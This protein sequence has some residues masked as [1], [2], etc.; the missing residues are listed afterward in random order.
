[1]PRRSRYLNG[2]NLIIYV[3][4]VLLAIL[5]QYGLVMSFVYAGLRDI[6]LL[7]IPVGG[8]FQIG[9]L[10]HLIPL[11]VILVL[12]YDWIY[13]VEHKA[14]GSI[15]AAHYKA[16]AAPKADRGVKSP[17]SLIY[18]LWTG[19]KVPAS[20]TALFAFL[21]LTSF[22][23]LCPSILNDFAASL[24]HGSI[25]F[26]GLI[27]WSAHINSSLIET[28]VFFIASFRISLEAPF[29]SIIKSILG[30]D[31]IWKYLICQNIAAWA[32]T[33]Y[34]LT[35]VRHYGTKRKR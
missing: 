21:L 6:A 9:V 26:R 2:R 8:G 13:L 28:L 14:A 22:I 17:R 31:L 11:N 29:K 35:Y 33:I 7:K 16:A 25:F 19:L 34:M 3:S 18:S 30:I 20:L 32:T 15:E 1:M 23:L 24:Y 4:W 5:I 10:F 27:S 12:C